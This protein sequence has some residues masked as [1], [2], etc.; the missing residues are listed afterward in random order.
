V[1]NFGQLI[2]SSSRV[3]V[4]VDILNSFDK[5]SAIIGLMRFLKN[6]EKS[7]DLFLDKDPGKELKSLLDKY[8]IGYIKEMKPQN[9]T[10]TINYGDTGVEKVVWDKDEKN[11]KLIFQI[12]PGENGFSF[13]DV[14]F[15]EGASK[16]DLTIVVGT[17]DLKRVKLFEGDGEY[18]IRENRTV[19]V[20]R[21]KEEVGDLFIEV[22][23]EGSF[24][25]AIYNKLQEAGADFD[26]E[27]VEVLLN[28]TINHRKI[29]EGNASSN[30]WNLISSMIGQ[31]AD[32]NKLINDNYFSKSQQNLDLQIELMKNVRR[33]Q[34]AKVIWS[35]V[36]KDKLDG[37]GV[38]EATLDLRGRIPFNISSD[39]DL[40]F[41]A[42]EIGKE[43]LRVVIESN[44]T[45]KYSASVIAGVFDGEGGEAHAECT[46]TGFSANDFEN[47][48]FPIL[49]D[50]YSL[51]IGGS[52]GQTSKNIDTVGKTIDKRAEK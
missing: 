32:F 25:E 46:M 7:A 6:A 16:Y 45:Q 17:A 47:R 33:D 50:L 21:G 11:K 38:T 24:S 30:S 15:S 10:I 28:G 22:E 48:L 49:K 35:V 29:L 52:Q 1:D 14:E 2:S 23:S 42:Y 39:F 43:K 13:D 51:E 27:T 5:T 41:A 31:G 40:A 34:N 3:L 9:Y 36:K 12:A 18:L 4:Y 26:K 19:V 44:D 20:A 8:K 37:S